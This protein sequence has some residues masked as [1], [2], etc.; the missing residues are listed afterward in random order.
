M[1]RKSK[2]E[3]FLCH[4]SN[5]K[6]EVEEIYAF[7]KARGAYPFMDKYSFESFKLW[8]DSLRERISSIEVAAIFIGKS[9]LGPWQTKEIEMFDARLANQS[10]C[11]IGLVILPGCSD[12]LSSYVKDK[13]K[14][15]AK[16]QWVDFQQPEPDPVEELVKIV[17]CD[18]K[19][20]PKSDTEKL[21]IEKDNRELRKKIFEMVASSF[22]EKIA[23][24]D[25]EVKQEKSRIEK[26]R[27]EMAKLTPSLER[28]LDP[29]LKEAVRVFGRNMSG[30]NGLA[31]QAI[32]CALKS[33]PEL[34]NEPKSMKVRQEI[35][36]FEKEIEQ[37]LRRVHTSLLTAKDDILTEPMDHRSGLK[38]EVHIIAL[39][40]VKGAFR[41]FSSIN[42]KSCCTV[43]QKIDTL[44]EIVRLR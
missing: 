44:I 42:E 38:S 11:N 5:D 28:E 1:G 4:N 13:W 26:I 17:K 14:F 3:I 19:T 43:E 10:N 9:G 23:M 30:M 36:W 24:L 15:L 12:E 34:Q 41:K 27:R 21:E 20:V 40:W 37:Y 16:R 32:K 33:C 22:Q 29:S 35:E 18:R 7:L 31:Q 8:E 6:P 25:L 39:T 2:S